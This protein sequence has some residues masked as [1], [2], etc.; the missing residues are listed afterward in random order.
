[1]QKRT[2]VFLPTVLMVLS[3]LGANL[4]VAYAK[5]GSD[6]GPAVDTACLAFNGTKPYTDQGCALCHDTSDFERQINPEWAWWSGNDLT[7]FCPEVVNQ[8]PSG[9]IDSPAVNRTIEAGESINFTASGSDPD[10]NLPL[11]F[12]WDFGGGA[13]NSN[14]EDPGNVRFANMGSYTVTLTV[15]DSGSPRLSD[16]TPASRVITVTEPPPVC[17]DSDGDGFSTEGGSCGL[18]DCDDGNNQI[19]PDAVE[20][21]TDG[22]DN[23]CNG[24][25]DVADPGAVNCPIIETCIDSDGDM[26]SPEGGYCGPIDCDDF[27]SSINPGVS[28]NCSDSLDNNCNGAVDNDDPKCNG[29]DCILE[30]LL[31]D[32]EEPQVTARWN[33]DKAKLIVIGSEFPSGDMVE[34]Y[35]AAQGDLL[36]LADESRLG[37]G[38]WRL[39]LNSP[40]SVP[41]AVEVVS[42]TTDQIIETA[43]TNAPE[44]CGDGHALNLNITNA[45]WN[46]TKSQLKVAGEGAP[47][48]STVTIKN[49]AS[50]EVMGVVSANGRGKWSLKMVMAAEM[51]PC[52]VEAVSVGQQ[53]ESEVRNAPENCDAGTEPEEELE[54]VT[55][56][57]NDEDRKLVVKGEHAPDSATVVLINPA[58][59]ETLGTEHAEDDGKWKFEIEK[60]AIAPCRI[61]VESDGK[62]AE[63]EVNNAPPNCDDEGA[64]IPDLVIDSAEWKS[65]DRKLLVSGNG[66]PGKSTVTLRYAS[67]GEFIGTKGAEDDGRWKFE[68]EKISPAPCSVS[69][70]SGGAATEGSVRNAPVGCE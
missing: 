22:V 55:A 17:T 18:I 31:S 57:W 25:I 42:R 66:A 9:V 36:G 14:I 10:S 40:A 2:A 61:R 27:D 51:S 15:T 60:P 7:N 43:V 37:D 16:S 13:P 69:V 23:N 34:I 21:C 5:S 3:L 59:G 56:D 47:I 19:N 62:S 28:E 64:G 11:S 48:R 30:E 6:F 52:E 12:E 41:C 54:I 1:M 45:V 35:D 63:A 53:D 33:A 38:K 4:P 65:G 29:E 58:T 44:N 70:D 8:E 39:A 46:N 20:I 49:A 26:F 50:G 24:L 68:I 67:T 32:T